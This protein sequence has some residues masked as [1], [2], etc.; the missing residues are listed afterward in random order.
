MTK[1]DETASPTSP[2]S[3]GS[4]RMGFTVEDLSKDIGLKMALE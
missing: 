3:P 4:K 1:D 2:V